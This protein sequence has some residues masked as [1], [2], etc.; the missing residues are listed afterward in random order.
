VGEGKETKRLSYV[1]A[2]EHG[3]TFRLFPELLA[4]LAT[5]A[6]FRKRAPVLVQALRTRAQE[7]CKTNG[8]S[9]EDCAD[10]L[11]QTVALAFL[12]TA[13]EVS[14]AKALSRL[15]QKPSEIAVADGWWNAPV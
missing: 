6:T 9:A 14:G 13:Q 1:W 2:V 11:A 3:A 5:Y 7:W 8:L 15:A 10:T 4:K 12:P